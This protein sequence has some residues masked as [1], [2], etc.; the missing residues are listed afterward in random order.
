MINEGRYGRDGGDSV[1]SGICNRDPWKEHNE[2]YMPQYAH[3]NG[4]EQPA[5][6]VL[7]PFIRLLFVRLFSRSFKQNQ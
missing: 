7:A 5:R 3:R 6:L 1:E 4:L 2:T